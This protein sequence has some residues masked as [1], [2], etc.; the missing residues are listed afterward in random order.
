MRACFATS[1]ECH[2]GYLTLWMSRALV[3]LMYYRCLFGMLLGFNNV[4]TLLIYMR[5]SFCQNASRHAIQTILWRFKGSI[6]CY[7]CSTLFESG[8]SESGQWNPPPVNDAS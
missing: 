2:V 1:G 4:Y 3:I 6:V 5:V 7:D 8:S